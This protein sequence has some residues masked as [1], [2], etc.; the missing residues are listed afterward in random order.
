[1][2]FDK[3]DILIIGSGMSGIVLAERYANVKGYKVLII[4]RRNHIGGNC[5]DY[6][7]KN[8]LLL[9]KYGPHLFHT[10]SK[11]VYNYL[12]GFAKWKNYEH[13]VLSNIDGKTLVRIPINIETINTI[14]NLDIKTIP[15]VK[16]WIKSNRCHILKPTNA[17]DVLLNEI[18]P[19]LYD[20]LYKNYTKK[21]WGLFPEDLSPEIFKRIPI[22]LSWDNRYFKNRYQ[23]FPVE[24]YTKLFQKMVESPN[25]K[26]LFNTDF[27]KL[28]ISLNKFRRIFYTGRIDEFPSLNINKKLELDHYVLSLKHLKENIFK[29]IL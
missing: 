29:K 17:K 9:P 27:R 21:Q 11:M 24:G 1:M 13:H 22:N 26:I 12:T 23:L 28:K 10:D 20:K 3:Y 8:G 7:D 6:Y 2:E 14:Y 4:E 18:G 25:I 16:K 5:Y 19:L 15:E